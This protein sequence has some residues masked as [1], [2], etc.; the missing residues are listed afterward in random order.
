MKHTNKFK[1]TPD[2][3]KKIKVLCQQLPVVPKLTKDG[4]PVYQV[5]GKRIPAAEVPEGTLIN[6]EKPKAGKFYTRTQPKMQMQNHEVALVSS[7]QQ[8]GQPG[9]DE[10]CKS[11]HRFVERTQNEIKTSKNKKD[12]NI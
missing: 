7:Y 8:F 1:V 10:Y 6:G 12:A 3:Y 9:I 2:V 11:V 4:K 5:E